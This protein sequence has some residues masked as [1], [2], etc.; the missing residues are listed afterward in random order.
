MIQKKK[1]VMNF[2]Y[3]LFIETLDNE[4]NIWKQSINRYNIKNNSASYR[5]SDLNFKVRG[6]I[7]F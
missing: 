6:Y 5:C 4:N 3:Q 1:Y 2:I 7:S